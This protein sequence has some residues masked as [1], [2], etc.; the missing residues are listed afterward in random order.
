MFRAR[1]L[2]LGLGLLGCVGEAS[3]TYKGTVSVAKGEAGYTFDEEPNP[4]GLAPISGATISLC[5][6]CESPKS[7]D[8]VSIEDGSWGPIEQVF[9]GGFS[10]TTIRVFVKAKGFEDFEYSATYETTNEPTDGEKYLNVRLTPSS[11]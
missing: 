6:D 4:E 10:D 1:W 7:H 5:T 8:L 11:R 3:V 9:G 2:L